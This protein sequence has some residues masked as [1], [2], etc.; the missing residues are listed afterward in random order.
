AYDILLLG[1]K[2]PARYVKAQENRGPWT[3]RRDEIAATARKGMLHAEAFEA[4]RR[5][6]PDVLRGMV[7]KPGTWVRWP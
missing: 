1:Q 4:L 6:P 2:V 5:A 3:K 7:S